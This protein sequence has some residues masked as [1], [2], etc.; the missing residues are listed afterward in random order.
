MTELPAK[1]G[2]RKPRE[3]YSGFNVLRTESKAEFAKLLGE[4]SLYI[5]P[6]NPIDKMYVNDIASDTWDIM[7]YRRVITGILNNAL[8]KALARILRQILLPPGPLARALDTWLASEN[9]AYDW[10]FTHN[11][12]IK[13]QVLSLLQEA[14]LDESAIE[15]EAYRLVADD[16]A[17][18]DKML[19]AAQDRRDK[20][21]RMIARLRKSLAQR[22]RWNSDRVLAADEV[23]SIAS[24]AEV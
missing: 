10:L 7:R 13:R 9:L 18:A 22:L 11:D 20:N 1:P 15:A 24:E 14:G 2:R 23:P 5:E 3:L 8:R 12:E 19:K 6:K 4:I 21:L 17:K 16:L